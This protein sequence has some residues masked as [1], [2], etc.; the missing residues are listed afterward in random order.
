M[1]IR[2]VLADDHALF[3]AGIRAVLKDCEGIEIV[4][5]AADGADVML[6]AAQHKPDII[7]M[8]ITMAGLNGIEACKRLDK[9]FPHICVIILS[10]HIEEEYV[11]QAL[12]A[13]ASGYVAKDASSSELEIAIRAAYRGERYLSP[14]VSKHLA[15]DTL[16]QV[17]EYYNSLDR[18]TARQ[19][20]VLQ[21]IAESRTSQE[22]ANRLFISI[23]TVETHR[24]HI[25]ERLNIH[26]VPGL[27]RYAIRM[28]LI[29]IEE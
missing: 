4:A 29:S 16:Q 2:I 19:R 20:E 8:D 10:M 5:E 13:G 15:S 24:A 21:L 26:D 17:G 3:R 28:R 18:L 23:K 25:M 14:A 1:P 22:I 7:V 9:E 12:Q 11:I 6:L 27:V